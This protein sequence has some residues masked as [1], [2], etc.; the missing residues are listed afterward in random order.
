MDVIGEAPGAG[1]K[2]ERVAK[3][4]VILRDRLN[5]PNRCR[6]FLIAP[7]PVAMNI[8]IVSIESLIG[9]QARPEREIGFVITRQGLHIERLK[10][11]LQFTPMLLKRFLV[12]FDAA[13]R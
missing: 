9:R 7:R 6:I 11:G 5:L 4:G 2:N 12:T 8:G 3:I 10:Q 13:L 1:A